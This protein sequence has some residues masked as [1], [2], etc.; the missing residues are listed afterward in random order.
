MTQSPNSSVR[1]V[2]A[3]AGDDLRLSASYAIKSRASSASSVSIS[4]ASASHARSLATPS[5]PRSVPHDVPLRFH[6]EGYLQ[7]RSDWLKHWETYYFVLRG[8]SLYC[9]L[10]EEDARRQNA[11]SKIKKGKFGFSD[12]VSLVK[13]WDVEEVL[14]APVSGASG[15]SG[16]AASTPVAGAGPVSEAADTTSTSS[17]APVDSES[18]FR[19]TLATQKGHQLHFRTNSEAS[20]HTWLQFVA[21]ATVDYDLAG[22]MRPAVQRL[23]TN[24]ADFYEGYEYFYA[25][26]CARATADEGGGRMDVPMSPSAGGPGTPGGPM[27]D[28]DRS[29][30]TLTLPSGKKPTESFMTVTPD[31]PLAKTNVLPPMDH[32]MVRFFSLLK[33]DVILR[34]NY[35]PMVPFEGKYRG[36]GGILEYFSRLSQS[37]QVEQF[38]VESIQMEEDEEQHETPDFEPRHR[39]NRNRVV[40]ISGRET[41]QVQH[42]QAT[43][44]L[45]TDWEK[46]LKPN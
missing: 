42:N 13:A 10:S 30:L 29:S 25:A 19:F 33:S 3:G 4:P 24:V 32:V 43:G 28:T 46:L 17:T 37:V 44:P 18:G 36:Y 40:V 20:K 39:R 1:S 15:Q 45:L 12:R 27:E 21:N 23:R 35:L 38:I 14:G 22:H 7:K 5:A 2:A 9:Y 6:W 26:L 31:Q 16:S 8:R 34:S 11:K 41:M